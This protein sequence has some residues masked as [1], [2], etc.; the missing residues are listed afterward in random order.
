[1]AYGG[2]SRKS[3]IP[4]LRARQIPR[5]RIGAYT[6]SDIRAAIA[7]RTILYSHLTAIALTGSI[8][9]LA[10][11]LLSRVER[12]LVPTCRRAVLD[13]TGLVASPSSPMKAALQPMSTTPSPRPVNVAQES[14]FEK[15][16]QIY[17]IAYDKAS[18]IARLY[19]PN[20]LRGAVLEGDEAALDAPHCRGLERETD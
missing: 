20:P 13:E 5:W 12:I 19:R 16:R 4:F 15:F 10:G 7:D 14:S 1:M 18:K 9:L 11:S 8:S 2:G 3:I 6:P 17:E